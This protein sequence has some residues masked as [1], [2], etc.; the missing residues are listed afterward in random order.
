MKCGIIVLCAGLLGRYA[1]CS[2]ETEIGIMKL[3]VIGKEGRLARQSKPGRLD[4][5]DIVYVTMDTP[6]EEII[7]RGKDA[8]YILVDAIGRL[9]G[10]VIGEMKKL[11]MI[12][13]EGVGYQG[14]DLQ[15]AAERGIYVCN[16]KGMNSSAVA[17]HEIMLMLSCLRSIVCGNRDV[18]AGRQI[19]RK[20]KYMLEG[21]LRELAD[22]V[23]GIVGFG[24]IGRECARLA[25][26]FGAE[27]VYYN[28]SA[29]PEELT[30]G[31]RRMEL[32]EV[33]AVSDIVTINL[34][35]TEETKNIASTEFFGKMKEGAI[36]INA[37]RGELVDSLALIEAMKTGRIAMAGLDC[38][39]GEPVESDNP[40]INAPQEVLD[41][42]IFS[43]HIAGITASSFRRGYE[44]FW[45]NIDR[46]EAGERP[47][48]IVNGL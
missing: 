34:P 9:T 2:R 11:R 1:Y 10:N 20:E 47:E 7:A 15:A 19:H 18:L 48:R 32:D 12:H 40:M 16:C 30:Y 5:K 25:S 24:D 14:I 42:I 44:M 26:A 13:S 38:V 45:Q 22:C 46:M 3:L 33:L 29:A 28:R 6:D 23:I 27:C 35:V 21:S 36:L 43:P 41:R 39:A 8:D 37:A 31:A 17:E 4:G